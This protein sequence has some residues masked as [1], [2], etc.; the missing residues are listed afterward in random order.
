M[1]IDTSYKFLETTQCPNTGLVPNW[2]LVSEVNNQSL[3]K[4]DGSFSGSG[5]PQ[6]EFGAEASRTMWR[7][8]F[9]AAAYPEESAVQSGS[10]LH[11]LYNKLVSNFNP[12]PLNGWEYFG[13]ASLEACPPIVSNVFGSWQWN[14]FISAPVFS[15]L[16]GKM[17]TN[18]FS[19]KSFNQQTMVDAA[20]SRVIDTANQSYYPLSWQVIAMMT[21]NGDVA[22]AGSLMVVPQPTPP[23]PPTTTPAPVPVTTASPTKSPVVSPTTT[24]ANPTKATIN[25]DFCCTWDFYHCGV[26]SWCNESQG[27]CHGSCG[28]TWMKTT[29]SSM[30]CIGKYG[31]CTSDIDGCCGSLSCSG[32]ESYKQCL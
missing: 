9:D 16:V 19:G 22:K 12:T 5:T 18:H 13:Q 28:G 17:S 2:A 3:K 8:A 6:Y 32:D 27:N 25:D 1:L 11:P 30:Q 7:V 21:L 14:Y 31:E 24:T 23:Q 10:F 29:A 20:C 15:T 4:H 26:D